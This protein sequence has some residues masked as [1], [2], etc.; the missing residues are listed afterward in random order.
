MS[1]VDDWVGRPTTFP[2]FFCRVMFVWAAF[3]AGTFV[4]AL[5][6]KYAIN[7]WGLVLVANVVA[8]FLIWLF[9]D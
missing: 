3:V 5:A 6:L 1:R 8:M 4:A 7:N 2:K 9:T